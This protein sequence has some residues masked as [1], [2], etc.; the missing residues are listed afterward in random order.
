MEASVKVM[1][2][3]KDSFDVTKGHL[4]PLDKNCSGQISFEHPLKLSEE[5]YEAHSNS[6]N[7]NILRNR[8]GIHA[9]LKMTMEMQAVK[10]VGRLPFLQS[11]NASLDSL[12]GRDLCLDFTDFL[13]SPEFSETLRQPHAVM[14]KSLGI[15]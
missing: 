11:S 13:N 8:E 6:L 10:K 5:K 1:P 7:M 12:I 14:E 9:P 3:M 2:G 4:A 15:L